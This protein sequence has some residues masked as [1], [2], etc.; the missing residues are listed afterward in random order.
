[1]NR[2]LLVFTTLLLL[3]P[4][5]VRAEPDAH[6]KKAGAQQ[7]VDRRVGEL[8]KEVSSL[9]KELAL[10]KMQPVPE[11]LSLCDKPIPL[12]NDDVRERFER[13]FYQFLENKGL[14]TI[15][16]KRHAK[17]FNV[18]SEEITRA[19]LPSDLIYLSIAESY[20]NPRAISKANAS[21]L[22]QFIRDTGK[23][24]GLYI[25]DQIDER[26]SV[27]R[28]TRSALGYLKKLHAEFGDWF[29][30]MAAYNAGEGRLREAIANQNTKDFFELYLPEETERYIH[31]VA[32]IKELLSN[33]KKYGLSIEKK[34][35]YRPFA[36]AEVEIEVRKE[37]PTCV[38]AQAMDL[39]YKAFREYNLHFRK[40]KLP[41]GFYFMYVPVEKKD[42]L[43]KRTKDS[44]YITVRKENNR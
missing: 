19:N 15:L 36:V 20:L 7:T 1:M 22:W 18:V 12:A 4:S 31:R 34:E 44:P 16:V 2:F 5:S 6:Q 10:L 11:T 41:K 37:V 32:A 38:L 35:Y 23:R 21:G 17:F 33:A 9:R 25:D 14:L 8:E 27:K 29:I 43:M 39:P 3:L 13:E 24:E 42:V 30:A 28:S 40:Y 26:Y